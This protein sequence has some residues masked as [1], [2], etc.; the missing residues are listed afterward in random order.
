MLWL[1]PEAA[2]ARQTLAARQFVFEP[3][4]TVSVDVAVQRPRR[5]SGLQTEFSQELHK[6]RRARP[7]GAAD[8]DF[9]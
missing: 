2:Q 5:V 1:P 9:V 6:K 4:M 7:T 3:A 8:D